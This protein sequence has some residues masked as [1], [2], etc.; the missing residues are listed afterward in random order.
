MLKVQ[1]QPYSLAKKLDLDQLRKVQIATIKEP[2][3]YFCPNG[4]QEEFINT[5]GQSHKSSKIPVILFTAG[6]GVGKT[7]ITINT[8]LNIVYGAKNGWYDQGIYKS[9]PYPRSI[10]YCSTGEAI[11]NTAYPEF[12]RL[13][14][15]G[16]YEVFKDGKPIPARIK[17]RNGFELIFKTYDQDPSTYESANVGL[18]VADEP[19]PEPLWRAVKSRRRMGAVTLLP[20]TPLYTP[21]YILDEVKSAVDRGDKGYFHIKASVYDVCQ[22][23]GVRGHLDPEIVDSMISSYDPEERQARAF[24]EFTYFSGLI[25]PSLSRDVHFVEPSEYPIPPYSKIFQVV[26]PHDS[27]MSAC[28]WGAVT[29]QNRYIVFAESPSDHKQ[30]YWEMKRPQNITKEV[31][32]WKEIEKIWKDH[33][34]DI[35]IMDRIF[36]WQNRGQRTLQDIYL[37]EGRK[38]HMRLA[39]TPSYKG[40]RAEGE[41]QLG[42]KLVRK[43]LEPLPDGK[44]ALVIYNTCYH[45]WNGLTHYVRKHETTRSSADKG[46]GEGKI[47]EKYKDFPDVIRFFIGSQIGAK[48][49][50]S[51]KIPKKQKVWNDFKKGKNRKRS[52][53]WQ[54][55]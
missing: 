45:T 14:P 3:K 25:Y 52:V 12:I 5:I 4:V 1:D 35:R 48:N 33:P 10:W 13:M 27:R 19:M 7:T 51:K 36:G 50:P 26:D 41:I 18:L 16:S 20:M 32:A 6:N 46:A 44:P 55:Q 47:V 28:I 9:F 54:S 34:V 53:G 43:A 49:V 37:K 15:Q 2:L 42:H 24:G 22:R 38:H 11:K 29:P 39:Y 21:P 17:F 31:Q 30:P 8:I 23:R 40:G